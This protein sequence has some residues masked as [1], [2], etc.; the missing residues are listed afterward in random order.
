MTLWFEDAMERERVIAQ[1]ENWQEVYDEINKFI[2]K[3][4]EKSRA[5]GYPEFISYYM[6]FN[7]T[8]C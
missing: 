1:V 4:N 2:Q 6:H 5:W 8:P 3:C 7:Y